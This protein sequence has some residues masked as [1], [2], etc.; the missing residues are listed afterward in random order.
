[1][2]SAYFLFFT[3]S[4]RSATRRRIQSLYKRLS[5]HPSRLR[6]KMCR[7][8]HHRHIQTQIH[9]IQYIYYL[10]SF[11]LLS[12]SACRICR[13]YFLLCNKCCHPHQAP[14]QV[15]CACRILRSELSLRFHRILHN[16]KDRLPC[17]L[18]YCI[19]TRT[20]LQHR[21]THHNIQTY[22]CTRSGCAFRH[23]HR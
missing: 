14:E 7:S 10:H 11:S 6:L 17:M 15:L 12:L 1:M 16:T 21:R 3:R 4:S 22:R 19:Y 18:K 5:F 13:I 23:T 8:F 2:L 9:T 20:Y